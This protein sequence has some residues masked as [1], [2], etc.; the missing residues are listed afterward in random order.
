MDDYI[1]VTTSLSTTAKAN[2]P[3]LPYKPQ[4]L[5]ISKIVGDA[6]LEAKKQSQKKTL[7][8]GQNLNVDNTGGGSVVGIHN[9]VSHALGQGAGM[10]EESIKESIAKNE[11]ITKWKL[12]IEEA[13]R[14]ELLHYV[15]LNF[16]GHVTL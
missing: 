10:D 15:Y 1:K 6:V 16:T 5:K 14:I 11:S 7:R 4:G 2:A 8:S 13:V 12:K 9:N 3:P